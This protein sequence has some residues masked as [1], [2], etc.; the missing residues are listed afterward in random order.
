MFQVLMDWPGVNMRFYSEIVKHRKENEQ[1]QLNDIR[2]CE[3]HILHG[4]FKIG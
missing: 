2:N 1:H 4:A 3:L